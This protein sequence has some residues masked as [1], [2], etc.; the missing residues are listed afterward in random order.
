MC[1][2]YFQV[3]VHLFERVNCQRSDDFFLPLQRI[4]GSDLVPNVTTFGISVHGGL[5]MDLNNYPDILVGAYES[6]TAF[7][8][9]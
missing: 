7:L 8:F 9:K 5:D 2:C 4:V 1:V 3:T 6:D